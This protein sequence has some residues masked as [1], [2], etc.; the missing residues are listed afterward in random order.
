MGH[1]H[2]DFAPHGAFLGH[3]VPVSVRTHGGLAP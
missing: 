1:G 3:A 2:D